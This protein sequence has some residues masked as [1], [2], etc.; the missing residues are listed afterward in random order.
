MAPIYDAAV[1]GGGPGGSCAAGFL[2]RAGRRVLVLERERFPRFR[3]GESLLPYNRRI[4]EELGVL[5]KLEAAGFMRKL[6]AQFH[7]ANGSRGTAFVVRDGVF[8]RETEAFQVERAR[9][10]EVL[11]RHAE[12]CGAEVREGWTVSRFSMDPEGVLLEAAPESGERERFRARWLI[13]ASGRANLTGNQE[14]LRRPHPRLQKIAVFSHFAGVR[15][16]EGTAAGDTIIVRQ[17]AN[18]FWIIPLG[19]ERVSVGL[20][21]DRRD[22][23]RA[24]LAPNELF[25]REVRASKVMRAR[26]EHARWLMPVQTTTDF[27][28]RNERIT[29]D[30]LLR[31][32]DAA[33]FMDPIFSAGVYLA[34]LSARWAAG[35]VDDALRDAARAAPGR[36]AYE[37][38]VLGA[39]SFYWEM[40]EAF[41]TGS[42]MEV[43]LQP[44]H[45]FHL[46]AAVNA[47]LA[48]ELEGGWA[49]RWR[50][51]LFF[52]IVKLQ[53][54]FAL[55]PRLQVT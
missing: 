34:M 1:I 30:R 36:R 19:P 10:D 17:A 13:D 8:N 35:V 6:G 33:G 53:T 27:S 41:Y 5:P 11:L 51:R 42:F 47:V 21:M 18:W 43:F 31:V 46:P 29:G 45:R 15:L 55:L 26:M 2:A 22:F 50:L 54:R 39:M 32:G 49:L 24:G 28:Y 7:L 12:S 3:I 9:F 38:K 16:D 20:V 23:Q 52:W 4:F 48:G 37:R 14:G 25:E 44:V 40:V